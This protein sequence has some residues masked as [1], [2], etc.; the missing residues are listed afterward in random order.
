MKKLNKLV[1]L[2]TVLAMLGSSTHAEAQSFSPVPTG[3]GYEDGI[4]S[5]SYSPYV[6]IGAIALVAIIA[7][8]VQSGSGSG[9]AHSHN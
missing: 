1:A 2:A 5:P 8:A 7:V 6:A 3:Y 9:H 4:C